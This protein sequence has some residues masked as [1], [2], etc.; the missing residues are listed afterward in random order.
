MNQAPKEKIFC[1]FS[2]S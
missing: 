2:V 1:R